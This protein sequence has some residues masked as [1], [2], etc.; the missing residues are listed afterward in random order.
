MAN[1]S[2]LQRAR[3]ALLSL[4]AGSAVLVAIRASLINA[5]ISDRAGFG[6]AVAPLFRAEAIIGL[7][8][9]MAL[10]VL[11]WMDKKLDAATRN[12]M[13][14]VLLVMLAWVLFYFG[15]Q[16]LMQEL[17][18]SG[19]GGVMIADSRRLFGIL[20]GVSLLLYA[21]M[22]ILAFFLIHKET[23]KVEAQ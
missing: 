3:V 23:R 9:G 22:T 8:C 11:V 1:L 15:S 10:L 16:P 13:T 18:A 12:V 7:V 5:S 4:W 14:G 2:L 17:R 21:Q 6:Q 20:H 19:Q